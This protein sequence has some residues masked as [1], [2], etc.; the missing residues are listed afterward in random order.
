MTGSA[1]GQELKIGNEILRVQ[2]MTRVYTD[3]FDLSPGD[4]HVKTSRAARADDPYC[5]GFF[6]QDWIWKAVLNGTAYYQKFQILQ[7]CYF[8]LIFHENP[9]V[10]GDIHLYDSEEG[11]EQRENA[12]ESFPAEHLNT[13]Y[14]EVLYK[15]MSGNPIYRRFTNL[16]IQV[17]SLEESRTVYDET[18][19]IELAVAGEEEE[20]F[21]QYVDISP[22][23]GKWKTGL[24]RCSVAFGELEP[25]AQ[26]FTIR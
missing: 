12:A 1:R 18:L 26:L 11:R 17:E 22:A 21:C 19:F 16:K 2:E 5:V 25:A 6:P 8:N 4:G 23:D 15:G 10:F 9:F 7:G 3:E 20:Y 13:L 24:Y 14:L